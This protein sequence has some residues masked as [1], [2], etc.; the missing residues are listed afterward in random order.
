MASG[1]ISGPDEGS[2]GSLLELAW[3]GTKP[4]ALPHGA[5]RTFL[6]DGDTV[7]IAGWCEGDGYRVGFGECTGT[8]LPAVE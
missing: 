4:V 1:T 3:R 6:E 8:I 2:R 5:T 7:E